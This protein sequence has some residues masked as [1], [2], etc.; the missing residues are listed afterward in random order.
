M[1]RLIRNLTNTKS[2][3]ALRGEQVIGHGRELK[4][5]NAPLGS[6]LGWTEQDETS[7]KDGVG[8]G[9][10]HGLFE[11]IIHAACGFLG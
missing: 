9:Q 3:P 11:M 7:K 5:K 8:G 10:T 1:W 4:D 2:P 6:G